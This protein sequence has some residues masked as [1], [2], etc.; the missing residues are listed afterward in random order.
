MFFLT[1]RHID[2]EDLAVQL[3]VFEDQ[4]LEDDDEQVTPEGVDLTSHIDV[5]HAIFKRVRK[6]E[7]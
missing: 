4:R 7:K 3:D 6:F 1:Y 5:F 2:D